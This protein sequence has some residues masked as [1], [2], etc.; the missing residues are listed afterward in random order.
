M[1]EIELERSDPTSGDA[2]RGRLRLNLP[3][4]VEA[5]RLVVTLSAFQRL[6]RPL[7]GRPATRRRLASRTA[8]LGGA[9]LYDVG[10]YA[11]ELPVPVADELET[12]P[13]PPLFLQRLLALF[14]PDAVG[15]LR[16]ELEARLER[17]LKRDLVQTVPLQ[18]ELAG[19]RH[20]GR[21]AAS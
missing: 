21:T 20:L 16:W 18:V 12:Y 17:R 11:F 7:S 9:G 15:P 14:V 1:L 3:E 4:A 6:R 19:P 13:D 5:R 2:C 8:E 10:E